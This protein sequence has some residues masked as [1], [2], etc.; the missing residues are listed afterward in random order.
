MSQ[1]DSLSNDYRRLSGEFHQTNH[2]MPR[3]PKTPHKPP[4]NTH[5]EFSAAWGARVGRSPTGARA[6]PV[7]HAESRRAAVASQPEHSPTNPFVKFKVHRQCVRTITTILVIRRITF[8]SS[9]FVRCT[10][11]KCSVCSV[12]WST[13]STTSTGLLS[14][15]P[16]S[17]E[18]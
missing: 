11:Y 17:S 4:R 2:N 13:E 8:D 6:P 9:E 15:S 16:N 18:C 5:Y 3:R 10:E 14:L 12:Y 1:A 7:H